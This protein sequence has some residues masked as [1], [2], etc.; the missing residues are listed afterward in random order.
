MRVTLLSSNN[1]NHAAVI[2]TTKEAAGNLI[3]NSFMSDQPLRKATS[4][5]TLYI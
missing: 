1:K 5:S 4:W 2:Y 3:K